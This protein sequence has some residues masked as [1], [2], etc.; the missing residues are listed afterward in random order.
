MDTENV[1]N[2]TIGGK[3]Y[4]F[5]GATSD[6]VVSVGDKTT[7]KYRTVTNVS[8]GRLNDTSTDA[9]NGSQLHATNTA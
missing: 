1:A 5:A 3:T 6:G 9:V 7:S 8:A 2:T 4:N